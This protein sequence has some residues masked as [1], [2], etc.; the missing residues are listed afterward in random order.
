[1]PQ[2]ETLRK[3]ESNPGAGPRPAS[4]GMPLPYIPYQDSK[5]T[6]LLQEGANPQ[7]TREIINIVEILRSVKALAHSKLY[8][9]RLSE[10]LGSFSFFIEIAMQFSR[11]P[12]CPVF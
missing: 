6:M 9:N 2:L 1:M 4:G 11:P 5:L 12:S 7:P 3:T 10:T 8:R